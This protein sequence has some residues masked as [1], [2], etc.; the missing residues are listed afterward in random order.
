MSTPRP[1]PTAAVGGAP[2]AGATHGGTATARTRDVDYFDDLLSKQQAAALRYKGASGSATMWLYKLDNT[3]SKKL[4]EGVPPIV[5]AVLQG[6][7][8]R[9]DAHRGGVESDRTPLPKLEC[10]TSE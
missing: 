6:G 5:T 4:A 2:P 1:P 10:Q 8:T 3:L 7:M 9:A